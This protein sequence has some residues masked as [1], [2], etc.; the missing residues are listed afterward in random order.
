MKDS[1]I[2]IRISKE[3]ESKF[4]EICEY[5]GVTQSGVL[6][7]LIMS[8]INTHPITTQ[9]IDV[10][11]NIE[12][13]PETNPHSYYCYNVAAI[14]TG[15]LENI[16]DE[17]IF[18]LPKF[19]FNGKEPYRID[20]HHYHRKPL[21]GHYGMDGRV[22]SAKFIDGLWRGAI[23]IYDD[24]LLSNPEISCF[25]DIKKMLKTNILSAVSGLCTLPVVDALMREKSQV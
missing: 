7:E 13:Y 21:P 20:S 11:F 19:I 22:L 2:R 6:R 10:Q 3:L 12:Q 8:Y 15:N 23:F 16:H 14:L 1:T 24:S 17:I 25:P 18:I 4:K 5:E 9:D